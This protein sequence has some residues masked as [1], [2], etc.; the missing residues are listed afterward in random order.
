[1]TH[2]RPARLH[3]ETVADYW[4]ETFFPPGRLGREAAKQELLGSFCLLGNGAST[5]ESN[6]GHRAQWGQ[7]AR[8]SACIQLC[9]RLP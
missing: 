6:I 5:Q 8:C 2:V 3:P 7:L 9:L 1:M 4:E